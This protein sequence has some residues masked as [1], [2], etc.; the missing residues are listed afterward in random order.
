VRENKGVALPLGKIPTSLHV[1]HFTF[2]FGFS[3]WQK[4][5]FWVAIH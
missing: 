2:E 3:S 4:P 5:G 1:S